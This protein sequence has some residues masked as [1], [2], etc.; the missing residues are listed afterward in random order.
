MT[1]EKMKYELFFWGSQV[2][3]NW[4]QNFFRIICFFLFKKKKRGMNE[5]KKVKP[6][7]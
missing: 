6:E 7:G 2:E 5:W 3:L 1:E 4:G